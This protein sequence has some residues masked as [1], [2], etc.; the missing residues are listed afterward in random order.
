MLARYAETHHLP[1][2]QGAAHFAS[3]SGIA[4]FGQPEE[5]A[6]AVA[7]LVS[8]RAAWINGIAL[9]VDGGETKSL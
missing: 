5:I 2:E 1:H 9:R 4:R 8:S 3:A 6:E 7:F